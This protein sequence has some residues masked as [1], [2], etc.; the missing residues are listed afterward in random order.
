ML[1]VERRRRKVVEKI[2]H[3]LVGEQLHPAIG[4]MDDEPFLGAEQLVRDD[5][6][7]DRVIRRAAAGVPDHMCVAGSSLASMQVKMA[8]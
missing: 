5:E 2:R 1:F 3:D 6:R 8:K 7:A 4:V